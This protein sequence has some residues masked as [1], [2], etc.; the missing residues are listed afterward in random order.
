MFRQLLPTI[1]AIAL[2]LSP[3]ARLPAQAAT[4]S[5]DSP[6]DAEIRQ[7]II[8]QSIDDYA[9]TCACP[10]SRMKNGSKCGKRSA[11]SRQGGDAPLCYP[12]DV[13]D[14]MVRQYRDA[15]RDG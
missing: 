9:G 11:Y 10:Y 3:E 1:F 15:H 2:L 6:T 7:R 12:G 4:D 14:D 5:S 8:Q 13:S